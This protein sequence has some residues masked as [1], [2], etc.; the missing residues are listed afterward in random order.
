M[1]D[2]FFGVQGLCKLTG[3][4]T[5][6]PN[7]PDLARFD[8]VVKGFQRFFQRR[9]VIPAAN[10]VKINVIRA[11]APKACINGVYDVFSARAFVVWSV[12]ITPCTLVAITACHD[13]KSL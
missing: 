6:R 2:W 3:I 4:H 13:V 10:L 8:N 11:E 7:I 1:E 5:G 12:S 9:F